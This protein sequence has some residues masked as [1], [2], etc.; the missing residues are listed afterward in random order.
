MIGCYL[1]NWLAVNLSVVGFFSAVKC[2][3]DWSVIGCVV[4]WFVVLLE[5]CVGCW[6]MGRVFGWILVD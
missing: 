6:L 3:F 4:V 1:V 5:E 2:L